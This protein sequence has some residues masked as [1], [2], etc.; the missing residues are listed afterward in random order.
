MRVYDSLQ[1]GLSHF[2]AELQRLKRVVEAAR[3]TSRCED[4]V[5]L[6]LFDDIL[7]GTNTVERQIAA[8][9]IITRL[10]SERV[11]G[12]V[13][14]HDLALADTPELSAAREAVHLSE[15]IERGEDGIEIRFDY[16]LR[17]GIA[18]TRNALRLVELVGLDEPGARE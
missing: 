2:M 16:R 15:R 6:Y 9:K 18:T 14:S 13:T 4:G 11:I 10:L 8:R 5:L 17:P 1:A 3:S 12:A 7:Q